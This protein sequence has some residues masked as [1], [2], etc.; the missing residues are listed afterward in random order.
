MKIRPQNEILSDI[1]QFEPS[2]EGDWLGLDTLLTELWQTTELSEACLPVLFRVF[3]RFPDD[4][5]A[6]LCWGIVHGVEA[7]NL[8]YEDQ[9]RESL[10][11]QPS[12]LG[13]VMLYRL[14]KW[15]ASSP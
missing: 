5:S 7:T 13:R 12:E 14:E 8:D 4:P 11:K 1:D 9:L 6:G 15:K 3:E 10:S 2:L